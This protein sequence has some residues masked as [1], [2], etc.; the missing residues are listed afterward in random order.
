MKYW[1]VPGIWDHAVQGDICLEYARL[2]RLLLTYQLYAAYQPVDGVGLGGGAY[3]QTR[4]G[5]ATHK[6][7]V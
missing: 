3:Q 7:K 2:R 5:V 4:P 6:Q 1:P